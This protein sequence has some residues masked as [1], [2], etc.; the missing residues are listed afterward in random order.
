[1]ST[2]SLRYLAAYPPEL[3][4]QVSSLLDNNKLGDILK[5]RYPTAHSLSS[6]AALY[7]YAQAIKNRFLRSSP[8]IGKV[9][10]DEKLHLVDNALGMHTFVSRIQGNRLKAKKEM[11]ISTLFRNT[12]EPFLH[13]II[14]H[15]LA[16]LREK[17]HNKA[18]Y[19]LCQHMAPNYHQ[20][21]LDV[22]LYLCHRERYGDLW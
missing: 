3:Q 6:G 9:I 17:A 7:D 4:S 8:P 11:R 2:K 5:M 15:E 10:Y 19:S 14:V 20:L 16:H 1:M 18:F 22:R 13:M 21:E 12:P